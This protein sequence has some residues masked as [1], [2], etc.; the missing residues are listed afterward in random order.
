MLLFCF[1]LI[2]LNR[3]RILAAVSRQYDTQ[4]QVPVEFLGQAVAL[5]ALVSPTVKGERECG[6][7]LTSRNGLTAPNSSGN[8]NGNGNGGTGGQ[9]AAG[10]GRRRGVGGD[11]ASRLDSLFALSR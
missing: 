6:A 1:F 10:G 3:I 11:Y 4:V 5:E 7:G 9:G 2:L 8:G